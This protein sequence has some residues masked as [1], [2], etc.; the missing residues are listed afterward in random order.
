MI[1]LKKKKSTKMPVSIFDP[2]WLLQDHG[3]MKNCSIKTSCLS[4]VVLYVGMPI[5]PRLKAHK[6]NVLMIQAKCYGKWTPAMW[7]DIAQRRNCWEN[8]LP[9]GGMAD[10]GTCK[11]PLGL[12]DCSH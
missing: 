7:Y 8:R 1:Q 3:F 9:C 11:Q 12:S 2:V 5:A 6:A 4:N 10:V